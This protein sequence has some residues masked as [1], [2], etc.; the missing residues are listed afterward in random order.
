MIFDLTQ[1]DVDKAEKW[2]TDPGSPKSRWSCHC[3]AALALGRALGFRVSV[4]GGYV[5][6]APSSSQ[7]DDGPALYRYSSSVR[8]IIFHADVWEWDQIKPGE[9]QVF[10][11]QEWHALGHVDFA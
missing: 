7:K 2:A 6:P 4:R 3:P 1:E 11:D 8:E 5:R 10:D 9:Y